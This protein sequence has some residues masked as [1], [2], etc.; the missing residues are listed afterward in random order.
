MWFSFE[1]MTEKYDG[2]GIHVKFCIAATQSVQYTCS[3]GSE[4]SYFNNMIAQLYSNRRYR[5]WAILHITL[6]V[7]ASMLVSCLRFFPCSQ[8]ICLIKEFAIFQKLV[9][10]PMTVFLRWGIGRVELYRYRATFGI[11]LA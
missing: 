11:I 8:G 7:K 9:S 5:A 4:K 6:L 10:N 2:G 1:T 3:L